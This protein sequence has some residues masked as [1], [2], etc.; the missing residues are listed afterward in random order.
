GG[1]PLDWRAELEDSFEM[2]PGP[3]QPRD[4][5]EEVRNMGGSAIGIL[6]NPGPATAAD[7]PGLILQPRPGAAERAELT[8]AEASLACV[9]FDR[10]V[11][12]RF[13]GRDTDT[14]SAAGLLSYHQD[15]S[16]AY[17]EPAPDAAAFLLPPVAMDSLWEVVREGGRLPPKSTY[18]APKMPSGLLFRPI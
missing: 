3:E 11:L 7:P 2:E 1:L 8:P 9:L 5:A 13:A 6:M 10:L 12:R 14:A 15:P 18:F 4:L 17:A 16:A